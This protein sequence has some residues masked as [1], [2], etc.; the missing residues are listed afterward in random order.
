[1]AHHVAIAILSF[2]SFFRNTNVTFYSILFIIKLY[3]HVNI[4]VS[5]LQYNICN[6]ENKTIITEN[7]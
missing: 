4:Y 2:C 1:M 6:T 7:S 3:N 5:L